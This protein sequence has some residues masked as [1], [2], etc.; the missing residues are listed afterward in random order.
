LKIFKNY[1]GRDID[2]SRTIGCPQ[3]IGGLSG[4]QKGIR[5]TSPSEIDVAVQCGIFVLAGFKL[6]HR[7]IDAEFDEK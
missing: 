1:F 2:Y 6:Q 7:M 5:A 3:I 4:N